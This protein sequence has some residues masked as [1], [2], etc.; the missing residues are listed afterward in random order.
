VG[1]DENPVMNSMRQVLNYLVVSQRQ[2]W[3]N[4]GAE[5]HIPKAL[6]RDTSGV[7]GLCILLK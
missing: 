1:N 2:F 4:T 3:A 6:T 7:S 5:L